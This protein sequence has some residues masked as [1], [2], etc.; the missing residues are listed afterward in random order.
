MHR[1]TGKRVLHRYDFNREIIGIMD[2]LRSSNM[3]DVLFGIDILDSNLDLLDVIE[4][5]EER[6]K[7][8]QQLDMSRKNYKKHLCIQHNLTENVLEQFARN[9]ISVLTNLYVNTYT[10]RTYQEYVDAYKNVLIKVA[11]IKKYILS[12]GAKL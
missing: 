9:N 2:M 4:T 7:V 6:G 1:K 11:K 12:K 3:D 5:A 8:M 10:A